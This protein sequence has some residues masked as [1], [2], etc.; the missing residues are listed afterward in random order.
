MLLR[1]ITQHV[2]DQNWFAVFLD[3][4]IVVVGILIAFQ[5]T[6]WNEAQAENNLKS[7]VEERLIAD[8]EIIDQEI[9]AAIERMERQLIN[10]EVWRQA[11]RRGA[12]VE[13]EKETILNAMAYG[14]SYPS[15][16]SRSATYQELQT[17][18]RLDL[19]ADEKFR[20]ALSKY[21]NGAQQR[22]FN[23]SEIRAVMLSTGYSESKYAE[24]EPLKRDENGEFEILPM[25][26]FDF[27]AMVSDENYFWQVEA[28]L[29]LQTWVHSNIRAQRRDVETVLAVIEETK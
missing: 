24:T 15:F 10:M 14:A 17:S 21:D 19:I 4:F 16:A 25:V 5:I 13:S 7:L 18:G 8:F 12:A 1:R 6:N 11:L 9:D 20:V 29:R 23:L 3:F 2:K 26:G 22:Q 27:E 28:V